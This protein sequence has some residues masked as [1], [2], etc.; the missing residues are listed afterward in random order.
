M[1]YDTVRNRVQLYGGHTSTGPA[2]GD[3]WEWDGAAWSQV[4]WSGVGPGGRTG[5][6]SAQT[7]QDN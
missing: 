5:H 4:T 2:L 7:P 3:M 1:T 6:A